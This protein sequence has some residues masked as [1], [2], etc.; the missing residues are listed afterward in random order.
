VCI[1]TQALGYAYQFCLGMEFANRQG[2]I[3][4][5]DLKPEN[6]LIDRNE[7][8]KVTDFGLA[9]MVQIREGAVPLLS[10]SSWPYAPPERLER[11]GTL[12]NSF[13]MISMNQIASEDSRSDIFA[14]GLVLY[15]M[16]M[17]H[18]PFS[19]APGEKFRQEL[20]N[21]YI[22]LYRDHTWSSVGLDSPIQP[23]VMSGCLAVDTR[24]RFRNFTDL[25]HA[26]EEAY[27]HLLADSYS[28]LEIERDAFNQQS[29]DSRRTAQGLFCI[30]EVS[31][32][33]HYYNMLLVRYPGD[34]EIALEAVQ[35]LYA[36]SQLPAAMY[37]LEETL[38][39]NPYHPEVQAA[40]A[41]LQT[42][43][44]E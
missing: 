28:Q 33:L 29:D 36:N 31:K 6:L 34:P 11:F 43:L 1:L 42:L 19:I 35:A 41:R 21:Y 37:L 40:F 20:A 17:G 22:Q 15:E 44:K 8:V 24:N 10:S 27:P 5:L 26:L 12:E 38:K 13:P 14:F 2:E 4:H 16:V 30:G 18:L 9:K 7:T 23:F 39:K 32:A 25:R 3:A